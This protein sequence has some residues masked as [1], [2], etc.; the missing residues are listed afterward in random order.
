MGMRFL[1]SRRSNT[2][3]PRAVRWLLPVV[4][5]AVSALVACSG[6]TAL[7]PAD[8]ASASPTPSTTPP[9][10][11][12]QRAPDAGRCT[13]DPQPVLSAA[14]TDISLI[15]F[16][17][18]TIVTSG[19]WLKNRQY[20]KVVTDAGNNAPLAPLYAPVDSV[21]IS[22]TH[23]LGVMPTGAELSQFEVRFQVSCEVTYWFDHITTL[24]PAFAALAPT[25]PARDTRD[26]AVPINV[27]VRAGDLI[28][29]TS[30]SEPAHTWDFILVNK[31]HTNSFANQA[32]YEGT[33]DLD[34]LLHADCPFDYFEPTLRAQFLSRFGWWQGRDPN[35]SCDLAVDVPGS[36]AGGW[37]MTPYDPN[38]Q[39]P[40]ADWGVV[41]TRAADGYVDVNGPGITLR[42][43]PAAPTYAD[44]KLVTD[45]HCFAH[46]MR[47]ARYAFVRLVSP[48]E[49]A[50]AFGDGACP[51]ELPADHRVYYR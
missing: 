38:A 30:G 7:T 34:G 2:S 12:G 3:L 50:V 43:G 21:A 14:Y 37:F 23:Y 39:F 22:V 19:N 49:L 36:I 46:Y 13:S 35:A 16:I 8:D 27:P 45:A 41:I 26:A 10:T 40:P 9:M 11:G 17:N 5:A 28:G 1:G 29:H 44:P 18:P 32:R 48:T 31:A 47:P 6:S 42:T 20:H 4:P 25:E 15:D 33:G 51:A 24:A